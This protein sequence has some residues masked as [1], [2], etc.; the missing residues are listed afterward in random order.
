MLMEQRPQLD[1]AFSRRVGGRSELVSRHV[2]YPWSLTR[3]FHDDADGTAYIIPQSANGGLFGRDRVR[4]RIA[5]QDGAAVLMRTQGATLVHRRS[6]VGAS[7]DW[8]V[9]VGVG[10]RAEMLNDPLVLG[11]D[12]ELAQRWDICL[13][14]QARILL[15]DGWTWLMTEGKPAFRSFKS[16]VSLRGVCAG[17]TTIERMVAT[18]PAVAAQQAGLGRPAA[19]FGNAIV[20]GRPPDGG[21]AP[22]AGSLRTSLEEY[23]AGWTGIG[24]LPADFGLVVRVVVSSAASLS[25]WSSTIWKTVRHADLG[26]WPKDPRHNV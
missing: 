18:P 10:A 6:G 5:I 21:W 7:S 16:E 25:G 20:A 2:S 13:A 8:R 24:L 12:A 4:Q 26:R 23:D 1:L 9:D 11:A 17:Q 22:L 14:P 19:A 15:V 3:P